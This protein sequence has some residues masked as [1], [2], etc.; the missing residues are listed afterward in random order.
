M[1]TSLATWTKSPESACAE[2]GLFCL[3]GARLENQIQLSGGP[4]FADG[5]SLII[6]L[7]ILCLS[8]LGFVILH[9]IGRFFQ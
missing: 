7:Y 6:A 2:S 3:Y 8:F 9:S 4:L 5:F 1:Q